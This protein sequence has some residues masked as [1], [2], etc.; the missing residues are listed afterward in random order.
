MP[1]V[2]RLD[3]EGCFYHVMARGIERRTIFHDDS[4]RKDF[5]AR[6][7][8]I[9]LPS[10]TSLYAWALMSNHFHLFFQ[11]R[12]VPLAQIMRRLMTGYAVAFNRRHHR[13]GHLFANRYK[14]VLCEKEPYFLELIR[15][16]HLNP[17]RAGI[18]RTLEELRRY[19]W[20]GHAVLMGERK[21]S[22]QSDAE[23]L[24]NFG[25]DRDEARRN[26][27]NFMEGGIQEGDETAN[28]KG[29]P[30]A[31]VWKSNPHLDQRI[32]GS[33][34]FADEI[35]KS[36]G[37]LDAE[38]EVEEKK[39]D[40]DKV[41]DSVS[42]ACGLKRRAIFSPSRERSVS[43]ARALLCFLARD[44]CNRSNADL[45]KLLGISSGAISQ[46]YGRGKVDEKVIEIFKQLRN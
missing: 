13:T 6:L 22:F 12:K 18:V 31:E 8:E 25:N 14:A 9:I 3:I 11:R 41:V 39:I 2:P 38:E 32:L 43:R 35:L 44:A 40:F 23:A 46:L 42:A 24:E 15:Y 16:V 36:T 20:S 1:R 37:K 19:P 26:L 4:D 17:L 28:P 21:A 30:F 27:E 5:I 29:R 45:Q 7:S 34:I 33:S 10:E